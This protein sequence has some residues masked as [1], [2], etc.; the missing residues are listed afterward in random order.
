MVTRGTDSAVYWNCQQKALLR[1]DKLTDSIV[2]QMSRPSIAI[3]VVVSSCNTVVCL[4]HNRCLATSG[5][6]R[7]DRDAA[8][9]TSALGGPACPLRWR[10]VIVFMSLKE[11]V[12][13][14]MC[15]RR[16]C[17]WATVPPL[18]A[19]VFQ[20]YRALISLRTTTHSHCSPVSLTS[21]YL[22]TRRTVELVTHPANQW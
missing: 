5:H 7:L 21:Q 13:R 19:S 14:L 1:Q 2:L 3:A 16:L 9:T 11:S 4:V 18:H 8:V 17:V 22:N 6:A 12:R 10:R 15:S 20:H